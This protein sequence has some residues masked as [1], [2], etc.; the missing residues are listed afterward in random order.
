MATAPLII[1][2]GDSLTAGYQVPTAINSVGSETPYGAFLQEFV[3]DRARVTV[4]GVCGELTG[5]MALRFRRDV[6]GHAPRFV[7]VL[8]GTNDLG[9]NGQPQEI[10]RNLLKMYESAL[11]SQVQPI[12]VTVPSIRV[13]GYAAE[14]AEVGSWLRDHIERRLTLNGLIGE[15]CTRRGLGCVDLFTATAEPATQF[16]AEPYSN[17]GLHLTTAGY[18]LLAT[19]LYRQIFHDKLEEA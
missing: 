7:V 16:L 2:F 13:E 10:M 6:L 4:S 8:G 15:Y 9:M 17:D 19:M 18:R 14:P 3:G 5:E 1:C 12:A 11:G